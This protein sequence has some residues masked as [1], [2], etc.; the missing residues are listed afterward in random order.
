MNR[1]ERGTG[2]GI[3]SFQS[4]LL[5]E[6]TF[7]ESISDGVVRHTL[8]QGIRTDKPARDIIRRSWCPRRRGDNL[9]RRRMRWRPRP[10]D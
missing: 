2:K 7:V 3:H 4:T 6:I 8:F 10:R 9:L 1:P 5:A